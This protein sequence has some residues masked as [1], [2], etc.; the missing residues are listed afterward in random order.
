M[1]V[2][3][4][5]EQLLELARAGSKPP[6]QLR[7]EHPEAFAVVAEKAAAKVKED[8]L[9]R[10][11]DT[12]PEL[13]EAIRTAEIDL[14]EPDL[15]GLLVA[16]LSREGVS[17]LE[18]K[19]VADQLR[20][21]RVSPAPVTTSLDL[22]RPIDEQLLVLEE[23]DRGRVLLVATAAGL[24]DSHADRLVEAVP[25]PALI[26]DER[27]TKLVSDG[28]IEPQQ[29][30]AIGLI[31]TLSGLLG[32]D[33][34][35]A[36]R[37]RERLEPRIGDSSG[38][39]ELLKL[40]PLDWATVLQEVGVEPV[41]GATLQDRGAAIARQLEVLFPGDAL[42]S[43]LIPN[44]VDDIASMLRIDGDAVAKLNGRF[45]G[46]GLADIPGDDGTSV[47]E[48]ARRISDRIGLIDRVR[49]LNP[50]V[51]LLSIDYTAPDLAAAGLK[52]DGIT[53]E[54]QLA[55]TR[56]LKAHQRVHTITGEATASRALLEAG[57][58]SGVDVVRER[59]Q[60]F[61]SR[62][63]LA[64]DV[65]QGI[66]EESYLTAAG[67][68]GTFGGVMD[69]ISGGF[70]Y[71]SYANL[72]PEIDDYLRRLTG[73][74]E[75]FG[76]QAYCSC[77]HCQSIMSPAAYFCDLM[78][79]VEENVSNPN[80]A[81]RA[82]HPLHL[83]T[84]REDLWKTPLTCEATNTTLPMLD[85]INEVLENYIARAD[86]FTGSITDRNAV[87][88]EVYETILSSRIFSSRQ[89]FTLPLVRLEAYL[90]HYQLSR[91]DLVERL[92]ATGYIRTEAVLT[93]SLWD[94]QLVTTPDTSLTVLRRV[95]DL[96]LEQPA[97]SAS[98]TPFDVQDL[99]TAINQ[100]RAEVGD[101]LASRFVA[102]SGTAPRIV[103]EKTDTDSVQND[104][105]RVRD[106]TPAALD[107]AYRML[108][109][110]RHVP[111]TLPE[112]DLALSQVGTTVLLDTELAKVA[113]VRA[114]QRRLGTPL[115]ETCALVGSIPT[116]VT[117]DRPPMFDRLF[118]AR[119]FVIQGGALPSGDTFVHP[120]FRDAPSTGDVTQQRLQAA[121]GVSDTT[122][123]Q[124]LR[125][126]AVRL[127]A[128][129]DAAVEADRGFVVSA[130]NLST[131][132]RHARLANLL[133]SSV[134]DLFR[135]LE[136]APGVIGGWVD[137]ICDVQA[138]LDLHSW[139]TGSGWTLDDLAVIGR[140]SPV[141]PKPYPVP[142]GLARQVLTEVAAAGSTVFA[143]TVF[144]FLE[145][146]TEE[147]S[148]KF[149]AANTNRIMPTADA[150][151]F[152][153]PDNANL[154]TP[155]T[156]PA[157]VKVNEPK[158]RAV[159]ADHDVREAVLRRLAAALGTTA[160]TVRGLL[161]LLAVDL[162][163][164]ELHKMV[165]GTKQPTELVV[166]I[167][168][169]LPLRVLFRSPVF[170]GPTLDWVATNT[171]GFEIN[172]ARDLS[173][174]AARAAWAYTSFS[175]SGDPGVDPEDHSLELQH[176]LEAFSPTS[177][178]DTADPAELAKVLRTEA[179]LV[180]PLQSAVSLPDNG[181]AALERLRGCVEMARLLSV[182]GDALARISSD[183]YGDLNSAADAILA[184][185]R[186]QFASDQWA[187]QIEPLEDRV[188]SA[189]RD[190]LVDHLLTSAFPQFIR[191][192]D[193]YDYFLVDVEA[194]GCVR[195]SRVVAATGSVQ[196][197][198]NRVLMDQ[199]Q[200]RRDPLDIDRVHV[201]P[202]DVPA[203]EWDWRK[204][205]R[206]W[207]ANRKVFLWPE[208]YIEPELR[209]DK[210]PLFAELEATLLQ[211]PITEQNV[212][213]AYATYLSGFE[214]LAQMQIAGSFHEKDPATKTDTLHLFGV[215]HSDPGVYYYR[216]AINAHYG[217]T[218]AGRGTRWTPWRKL[219][220]Q[221]P[222]RKV[223]PVVIDSRLY[224]F[225]V[226]Y[227]TKSTSS[228]NDG[229]SLFTG[230]T[231]TASVRYT[232]L[233]LD[234]KWTAPQRLSA[235]NLLPY[236]RGDAIID[237]PRVMGDNF[238]TNKIRY[239]NGSHNEAQESYTLRGLRWER[240][241]PWFDSEQQFV[242]TLGIDRAYNVDLFDRRIYLANWSRAYRSGT[243]L[244]HS[245]ASTPR[246]LYEFAASYSAD[247]D[248][249]SQ[250]L[251]RPRVMESFTTA[252]QPVWDWLQNR[253][254]TT[255]TLKLTKE[256]TLAV[257]NGSV[258]DIL[259]DDRGDQFLLQGSVRE[260][261]T[262][263]LRRIGTTLAPKMSRLL[264]TE[265]VDGLLDLS[266]QR[267]VEA[268]PRLTGYNNVEDA[269]ATTGVDFDGAY[270]NYFREIFFHV[271][272]LIANHLNS[273]QRFHLAQRWYK[274]IFDPT[275]DEHISQSCPPAVRTKLQLDRV[276]RYLEFRNLDVPTMRKVLTDESAIE[277]YRNDPFNPYAIARLRIS[278]FQKTIV[279]KYVDNLL[280][281][282]DSLFTEFTMESVN[283][284]TMMYATASAILGERP[285][286]L[287]SCGEGD[288]NPKNYQ[289]IGPLLKAGSEFLAEVETWTIGRQCAQQG[290]RLARQR[291]Q[292]PGKVVL[293]E[294]SRAMGRCGSAA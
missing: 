282:G 102:A 52:L 78:M 155:L 287:G 177:K 107:R 166:V 266:T 210:S 164:L 23:L 113:E 193:L 267:S 53:A 285:P 186:A 47:D 243:R 79:F 81:Q 66:F 273:N 32:G 121:L 11:G 222:V 21:A 60:A 8:V 262:Y 34:E 276:W 126:L 29:A 16:A 252:D 139:W 104:I 100:S 175:R 202:G 147:S 106:L 229:K 215:T 281:W 209:D 45:P 206:V 82:D 244:L 263:L 103:P 148:R 274:Y 194:E 140:M 264:F 120:A 234:G 38:I 105:E 31:S 158:A 5:R 159:L 117:D 20:E 157:G 17:A 3:L 128:D 275:A 260:T 237:D 58:H 101:L 207:E 132:Y 250:W 173:I 70:G 149:V 65:A 220:V 146:M 238:T 119:P 48:K 278:A 178:F 114:L 192:R 55:V 88:K 137:E 283:E 270:G 168:D 2:E 214:D 180:S 109:L 69:L 28:E 181:L 261:P 115:D 141:D 43:R 37:V 87:T 36:A 230:Y 154:T 98:F 265:G 256:A 277:A 108:R 13:V 116:R 85:V 224:V 80:F 135:L 286:A 196:L 153:V 227:I 50:E 44:S 1:E 41:A 221:I 203:D 247:Y 189:K 136:L 77:S 284:A 199:E 241:Y 228:V 129:P 169:L 279:M 182:G 219:D 42:A 130:E 67:V 83:R 27:L 71:L 25:A 211:Q 131:L 4:N 51:E 35:L 12:S 271:P 205:H 170:D 143:D 74:S 68:T 253:L 89:P 268:Q 198:V 30:R 249:A 49:E 226:E 152:Q 190:A 14:G 123:L 254:S 134:A 255:S 97:G 18:V 64:T 138:L 232:M 112:L 26:S 57:F 39:S 291:T 150:T 163:T 191:P 127:G 293:H 151:R 92:G 110:W 225:W 61:Q 165:A 122:L 294:V 125:A 145:E 46:L 24:E 269:V 162:S 90:D 142:T 174:D 292:G 161:K 179:G 197:Y 118:N 9:N 185:L 75:L 259:I 213:D 201:P 93:L 84:R 183:D 246:Y 289:T 204:N 176:V 235:W 62:T 63:G 245:P 167:S 96:P 144:A 86:G 188:R 94:W 72:S 99:L 240:T 248:L 184:G 73:Y 91:G 257:I 233:R 33:I 172:D 133:A 258:S 54:D 217:V 19:R 251:D 280:D 187:T 10:L 111:W 56:T 7:E 124:L 236:V 59:F 22:D 195:T 218:D 15:T 216:T 156:I 231:H 239:D 288:V 76:S 160:D 200:D 171:S 223:S 212:L 95:F 242:T 6:S 290:T 40:E 208:N 272:F